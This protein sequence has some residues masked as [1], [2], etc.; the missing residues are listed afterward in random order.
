MTPLPNTHPVLSCEEAI[1]FEKALFGGDAGAEWNAM[2]AAGLAVAEAVL[3]DFREIGGFPADGRVLVLCGK[4]RNGGDALLAARALLEKFP[5]ASAD[6][7]FVH[8]QKALRPPAARAAELLWACRDRV[9]TLH[10]PPAGPYAVCLDGIFGHSFRGKLDEPS[11]RAIEETRRAEISLRAA[12]DLPSG[13]DDPGAFRAD[14]SYATGVVKKPLLYLPAAGR[15]RYL[16][17]GFFRDLPKTR[18]LR[19]SWKAPCRVLTT[20]LL[21]DLAAFRRPTL[22]KYAAGHV[23]VIGGS[24]NLPGAVLM[25][26]RAALKSGAGL[27]SAFVPKSLVP[28][29][30]A[31][32]P[33]AM[34]IGWPELPD[35]SLS[36]EGFPR[37]RERL[38]AAN[39][40]V[41]GPGMGRDPETLTLARDIIASSPVPLVIDADALQSTTVHA[42]RA[43][44]ILTPHTG[45]FARLAQGMSFEKFAEQT[46]GFIT[47]VLKGPVTRV[48]AN[49][50]VYHNF[51]GGPVLARAGS[52]DLLAGLVG[53]L[54][55]QCPAEPL[56]AA[57]RG[58][59]WHGLAADALARERGQ[60]AVMATEL[61]EFLPA[62]LRRHNLRNHEAAARQKQG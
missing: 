25:S 13:L 52:G 3:E 43:P 4:G 15:P 19:A 9:Q 28:A 1:A 22:H 55:A 36:P 2:R 38:P 32:L 23:F 51:S 21:A 29:F 54:L 20:G 17:L 27:V 11:A 49:D 57:V 18:A 47:T 10:G 44:R 40:L 33:E 41:I 45:E 62:I 26:V 16:D 6:V 56:S 12:V 35:G 30:A 58:V 53:G 39:A 5:K 48:A 42:G 59:L 37:L 50:A 8:G 61:L 14:F 46:G 7:R 24:R 60:T 34:W 31:R